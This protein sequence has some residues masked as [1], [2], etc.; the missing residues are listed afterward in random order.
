MKKLT[1]AIL[2]VSVISMMVFG[3]CTDNKENPQSGFYDLKSD[4]YV[5]FTQPRNVNYRPEGRGS[6][7]DVIPFYHDGKF[8]LFYLYDHRGD[9]NIEGTPWYLLETENMVNFED[10]GLALPNTGNR[11]DPDMYAFTGSVIEKDGVFHAFYTGHNPYIPQQV[12]M[13][14][15]STDLKNWTKIPE[16][17]LYKAD[18]HAGT[19]FRDPFVFWY[20]EE[21]CYIMLVC[22]KLKSDPFNGA[23]DMY[24][25]TDLKTWTLADSP[26]HV[27]QTSTLMECPDV[28]KMGDW[29]YLVY[30]CS[31]TET[32]YLRAKSLYG[33]WENPTDFD[34]ENFCAAK[35]ASD[36]ER[37]YLFGWNPT[38]N[39]NNDSDKNSWGGNLVT[40]EIYPLEDGTL[41]TKMPNGV[42]SAYQKQVYSADSLSFGEGGRLNVSYLDFSA[43]DSYRISFDAE[44]SP[45]TANSGIMINAAQNASDNYSFQFAQ[46]ID[47]LAF[48]YCNGIG[49]DNSYFGNR[50]RN[51]DF[52]KKF[53][54]EIIVEDQIATIYIDNKITLTVRMMNDNGNKLAFFSDG[55]AKFSNIR[56][57]DYGKSV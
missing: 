18:R 50:S 29:W 32:K 35:T 34:G 30:Y 19:D 9:L 38:K 22:V 57:Y 25:S 53:H 12:V 43:S 15:T 3:G 5:D 7:A 4:V 14:A 33:P 17:T 40:Y 20:E 36:G 26:L 47:E 39:G 1:L 13:H 48:G 49:F 8:E 28:F 55:Q 31:S 6:V 52:S 41:A 56:V 10:R 37:R 21:Q 2:A 46:E 23:V 44:M 51:Y 16:D 54:C 45:D 24:K 27:E 42:Y 11:A